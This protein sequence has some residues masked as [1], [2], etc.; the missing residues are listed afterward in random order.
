MTGDGLG[1]TVVLI[2]IMLLVIFAAYYT[3]KVLSLKTR[4]MTKCKY[5]QVK[6]RM[7]FG[8]DKLI[9]LLEA[10]DKAYLIGVTNQNMT[11]LGTLEKDGLETFAENAQTSSAVSG[12]KG[13]MGKVA[14]FLKNAGSAQEEL[15]KARMQ[16]KEKQETNKNPGGQE[17]DIEKILEVINQ[18]KSRFSN[19]RE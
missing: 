8:R 3:T 12:M 13:F 10:G 4:N 17:D 1:S 14:G 16:A 15:R 5:M 9:V 19:K 11:I 6:D 18:R 7:F 2:V